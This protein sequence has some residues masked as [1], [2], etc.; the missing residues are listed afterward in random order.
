MLRRFLVSMTTPVLVAGA[1]VFAPTAPSAEGLASQTE[2]LLI[3]PDREGPPAFVEPPLP[4]RRGSARRGLPRAVG[5]AWLP[6]GP[7]PISRG[8][9][10]NIVPDN[11]VIGAIHTAAAH[12]T[13]PDVLYIGSV[14]GGVWKT[15]DA[16]SL[17][18]AWTPT[19]DD[20]PA[21]SVGA[22]EFDPLDGSHET[23][24]A[25]I[26]R[27]SSY[28]RFGSR[29]VGLLRTSDGAAS[30]SL[31]DGGGTLA[32][33]NISG[34]APRGAILVASVNVDDANLCSNQGL[35]RSADTG[36]TFDKLTIA[37]GVPEG[38]AYDLASDPGD[39]GVLYTGVVLANICS[40]VANGLFRSADTGATWV[41][42]SNAAIEALMVDGQTSNVEIA[43]GASGEVYAA[44][45]NFGQVA[46]LFRSGDG[47]ANW[48]EVDRPKTNE[49]GTDV[50]VNPRPKGDGLPGGQG[51]I[52]FSLRA[53][54]T[55][56]AIFYVGGDR[57]PRTF[58]DTG[59]FPNSI[60]ALDFSG[61]LFRCDTS[62]APGSQCVHLTHR[63]DLGPVGGGTASSSAPHADSREIVFD[64]A[65][66]LIETDDGGVFRRTAPRSNTGDWFSLAG[67][68]QV[69]ELHDA[70]LDAR[71]LLLV[72]GAQDTGTPKQLVTGDF[73]WESVST[74]D[75]GDVAVDSFNTPF[76]S[77][78][79]S[80]F[81]YLLG[82]RR[83]TYDAA[84]TRLSVA[85]PSLAL[86]GGGRPLVAGSSG[87]ASFRT[88]IAVG[89]HDRDRLVVVARDAVYE[90]FDAGASVT[91]ILDG[92]G[93]FSG[94][95]AVVY[96]GRSGGTDNDSLLLAGLDAGLWL[97]S[98]GIGAPVPV[99]GYPGVLTIRDLTVD[100]EE[101]TRMFVADAATVYASEDGGA[102][103]SDIT[104]NL[105]ALG[106]SDLRSILYIAAPGDDLL[107]LG[108]RQGVFVS[109]AADFSA[110]GTL[111]SG[112]PTV[113]VFDLDYH[114]AADLLVAGTMGRG[115]WSL[116][117]LGGGPVTTTTTSTTLPVFDLCGAAPVD[118]ADCRRPAA[119]A[120]RLKLR[121][122]AD[123]TR[124]SL[125][126]KWSRGATTLFGDFGDPVA[127]PNAFDLCI[128]DAAGVG[129]PLLATTVPGGG[130]CGSGPCWRA[131]GTKG[132]VFKDNAGIEAGGITRLKV[133]SGGFGRAK[134]Q[135]KARGAQLAPP[136]LPLTA[137]VTVQ[138][139]ASV[140][141]A[142]ECWQVTFAEA[143]VN[144]DARF[145]ATG[146]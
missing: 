11:A 137:P 73:Y 131:K 111:G 104:G 46:G 136:L 97:R 15:E 4:L 110:W 79:Y 108:S 17:F 61:R 26:G 37:D 89:R 130:T 116:A 68:L 141:G 20:Q 22:L 120:A 112:L 40:G 10:E 99:G 123:D 107:V 145:S 102:S 106:A 59:G 74:A 90:S 44:V 117:G 32:G 88:P 93:S 75:G 23:L 35:F 64:A 3:A 115:A 50:G 135:L 6:E 91:N 52:H 71:S 84:G 119:S 18:P 146:P 29:L 48:T 45:I 121:D 5:G 83:E 13:D 57:Q 63:N 42:V 101:W 41:R 87:N 139:L 114:P 129:Q 28:G 49:N 109:T 43:V 134:I 98:G 126:W 14:N 81:Q 103:W 77:T 85:F 124:D 7:G 78:R 36:A 76:V 56:A 82:F 30:W 66:D 94:E 39:P 122:A 21:L 58:G 80:S 118:P 70:A 113:P 16:T 138:L 69:T 105:G 31:L 133:L 132:Y 140:D 128:Y 65:G 72:G 2:A 100:P 27:F 24:V 54:P 55:D 92:I 53:D 12:P 1:V 144:D 96:G 127:G 67:D 143:D 62:L 25:G 33:T 86:N 38:A 142:L 47:G 34:V 60:G 125:V 19:T 51:G 9:V 8:Q 95:S